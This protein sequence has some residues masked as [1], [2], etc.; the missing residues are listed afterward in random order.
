MGRPVLSRLVSGGA[1]HLVEPVLF[2]AFL[3][4]LYLQISFQMTAFPCLLWPRKWVELTVMTASWNAQISGH[5]T[6]GF[7]YQALT[8]IPLLRPDPST[9]ATMSILKAEAEPKET[10]TALPWNPSMRVDTAFER[11]PK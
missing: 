5:N 2:H 3:P 6:S 7:Y 4:G 10:L 9:M 1:L 8:R 11:W